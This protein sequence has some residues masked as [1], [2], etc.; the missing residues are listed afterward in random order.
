MMAVVWDYPLAPVVRPDL[1]CDID[2]HA[3]ADNPARGALPGFVGPCL[4]LIILL[5]HH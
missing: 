4:C 2:Q 1:T 3:H 5:F